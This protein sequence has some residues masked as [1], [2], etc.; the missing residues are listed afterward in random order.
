[1]RRVAIALVA[2]SLAA[3]AVP[4]VGA[5]NSISDDPTCK[6]VNA[7]TATLAEGE[8]CFN[9]STA[10]RAAGVGLLAASVVAALGTA[11]VGAFAAIRDS[12]GILF[13]LG[14]FV[15]FGFFA[16]ACGAARF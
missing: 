13:A 16:A 9:G 15:A 7:G 11:L 5:A 12:R 10:R 6:D 4:V 14:L 1:V 2:L 8:D 3:V